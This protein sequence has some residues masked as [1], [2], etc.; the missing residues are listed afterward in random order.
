MLGHKL[1]STMSWKKYFVS[2]K[3]KKD[4]LSKSFET[5]SYTLIKDGNSKI[6]GKDVSCNIS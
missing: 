5:E 6:N 4:L 2:K 1:K 3:R